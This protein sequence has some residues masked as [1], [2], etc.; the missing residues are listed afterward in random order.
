MTMTDHDY[1]N[2]VNHST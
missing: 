1:V 2:Y